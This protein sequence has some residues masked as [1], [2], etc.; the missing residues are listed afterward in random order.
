[1]GREKYLA[2]LLLAPMFFSG[3]TIPFI[4]NNP[5]NSNT[6][7]DTGV[8]IQ[9]FV[10]DFQNVRSGEEVTFSLKVKNTGSVN[11]ES[12]F[13]ELLGLDQMWKWNNKN[14]ATNVNEVFPNEKE[15]WY[16]VDGRRISLLPPDPQVGTTGGEHVCTWSYIAPTVAPGLSIHSTPRV[17]FYYSSKSSTIKTI[18]VASREELKALENEGKTLPSE[19]YSKT[20]SPISIDIETSTPIRT[21]G[22]DVGFPLVITVKNVGGGTVCM[23]DSYSCKKPGG[24]GENENWNRVQLWIKLPGNWGL[25]DCEYPTSMM[26]V[27]KDPQKITC[28]VEVDL[29]QQVGVAQQNV[30]VSSAYGYFIDKTTDIYVKPSSYPTS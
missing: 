25:K 14:V 21:Y 13:A 24:W 11:A 9:D 19:A 17:R 23:K 5:F 27:G 7:A 18:T 30:E 6:P 28:R 2:I 12:G 20:K 4:G 15:C 1:M 26:L 22:Y 8:I 3:C 29:R 16:T 10:P